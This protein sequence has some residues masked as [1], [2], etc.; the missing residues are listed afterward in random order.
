M[1]TIFILHEHL[2]QAWEPGKIRLALLQESI[3][4]LLT[5]F[6]HI[7]EHGCIPGEFLD[8]C[9]SVGIRVESRFQETQCKRAFLEYLLCP[10][11]GLFF[12][13]F[14]GHD[15]V[16]QSH[17]QGLLSAILPAEIP[18]LTSLFVTND[19]RH[20]GSSPAGI[21]TADPGTSLSK[22]G[23][24]GGN[25]QI[26][27]QVQHVTAPDG[28]ACD[29]CYDR[30]GKIFDDFLQVEGV[31]AGH[32]IFADVPAMTSNALITSRAECL[33]ARTCKDD[34]ANFRVLAAGIEGVY[35]F[36]QRLWPESIAHFGSIDGNL[37]HA[38]GFF[39]NNVRV[40]ANLLPCY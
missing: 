11:Y 15:G 23:I 25:G 18:D 4:P 2:R 6:G 33:V 34:Y 24:I 36:R 29:H 9:E 3:S 39:K 20:V 14:Q 27:E 17:T 12:Q 37:S 16:D 35:Q 5:L 32:T 21:K 10:L 8:T 19:A 30:L 22:P 1:S 40:V 28:V 26:A 7:V 38:L 31:Q 13:A